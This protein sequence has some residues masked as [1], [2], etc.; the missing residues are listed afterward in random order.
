[1]TAERG[2]FGFDRIKDGKYILALG[3]QGFNVTLIKLTVR[4][5]GA[6]LRRSLSVLA[7]IWGSDA[8]CVWLDD[9]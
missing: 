4:S 1:M 3:H 7:S 2:K 8:G 9:S 6:I 5:V